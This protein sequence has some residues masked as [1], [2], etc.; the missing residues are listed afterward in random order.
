MPWGHSCQQIF[1]IFGFN[2]NIIPDECIA[3][4]FLKYSEHSITL[5]ATLFPHEPLFANMDTLQKKVTG[6]LFERT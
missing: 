2:L 4:Q 5:M 1:P 6:N 3:V